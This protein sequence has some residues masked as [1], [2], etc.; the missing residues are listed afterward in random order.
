L[1]FFGSGFPG[2]ASFA[3]LCTGAYVVF[4]MQLHKLGARQ[5]K[6]LPVPK[7]LT[8]GGLLERMDGSVAAGTR[9][10]HGLRGTSRGAHV[11]R[12]S[13]V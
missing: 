3:T 1:L 2:A 12:L 5:I 9:A 6:D 10:V 11:H 13:Y 4:V 8:A 7:C